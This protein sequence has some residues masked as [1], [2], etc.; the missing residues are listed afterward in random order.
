M[1]GF[2]VWNKRARVL[3]IFL[4]RSCQDLLEHKSWLLYSAQNLC[5][6]VLNSSFHSASDQTKIT[7]VYGWYISSSFSFLLQA[8]YVLRIKVGLD[9]FAKKIVAIF[10]RLNHLSSV[11][12]RFLPETC[13]FP[14]Y[15]T[16]VG[17]IFWWGWRRLVGWRNCNII[18]FKIK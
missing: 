5:I 7:F 9:I 3:P 11:V 8:I 17:T 6:I 4:V 12:A 14:I 1:R 13:S 2:S 15:Q 16:C 10:F 18:M